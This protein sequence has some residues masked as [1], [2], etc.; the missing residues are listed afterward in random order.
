MPTRGRYHL[1]ARA[2]AGFLAQDMPEAELVIVSEDGIP[3][4]IRAAL[5]TGRVRH[6]PCPAG[7]TLGAKRN[8]ACEAAHGKWLIHWDDDDLY[9]PDRLARQVEA[10]RAGNA[11]VSGSSRVHFREVETGSCWEYR[12]GG[13]RRPWVYGATLAYTREFWRRHPFPAI[14]V[15]EDNRFVW[16]AQAREVLDLDDPGLCLCAIHEGNTS[17]KNTRNAWWRPIP[18]PAVWRP[19]VEASDAAAVGTQG[20]HYVTAG[21]GGATSAN[22]NAGTGAGS[23]RLATPPKLSLVPEREALPTYPLRN[24]Y[25]CLVHERL[26]CVIDLVRNLRHLDGESCILLY[27]GS[28]GGNQLDA[29]LPW[30]RWSVEIVPKARPIKWGKLHDFAL[31]CARHL[32][33]TGARYDAMTIV[34]SDQLGLRTGYADFLA[35]RLGN[36]SGLGLL[37]SDP[38]HQGPQTRIPPAA[39]AQQEAQL[40]R[41]FL[42]RFQ[43]GENH[44]VHWSFWPSTVLMAEAL[45]A[46]VDLFDHDAE[47]TRILGAS[48]LWATEEVLFPTLTALLGFRVE[49]NP[50]SQRYVKYR[51]NYPVRDVDAALRDTT[52]FWMHPVPRR[53]DEPIR[54]RIRDFHNGYRAPTRADPPARPHAEQLWPML[55]TMRAIEGWLEDE[56]A[57]LL[58][59]AAREVLSEPGCHTLVEVGSYCGKATFVLA[60]VARACSAEACVVA[61]DTFDG[62]VGSLDHGLLQRG[63]TLQK[64]T[65]ML[66][67]TAL[68][69]WV[70]PLVGRAPALAW[71]KPVDLLLVD[72]LHDYASVVQDFYAF[73]AWLTPGALV[74]FH[75]YADYFPGVRAFVDELLAG[76]EWQEVAQAGSM[77]LL[78]RK[79]RLAATKAVTPPE[80]ACDEELSRAKD[81]TQVV[82][83]FREMRVN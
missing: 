48:K 16:A 6:V 24:V 10:M 8:F 51:V 76:D 83:E 42:R 18:L 66:A 47:L 55:R 52:A 73:E 4:S 27:D 9:A 38:A 72:G 78:R 12:Y 70:K 11:A 34:D 75:D 59:I 35:R 56:E 58:V 13:E 60:S 50:C 22:A 28:N 17:A 82:L 26:D 2:V 5:A 44:F 49:A 74:A 32:Q 31:D 21:P 1:L 3:D 7:L 61:I 15:S 37:S 54:S 36:R 69:P 67:E 33:T 63:P 79:A 43:G 20:D 46:L 30:S 77:K 39:T 68:E 41:P 29:R 64:F 81:N 40:W 19:A 25:A 65:C 14:G 62:V 57:E 23:A 80:T 53:L 45:E 71:D